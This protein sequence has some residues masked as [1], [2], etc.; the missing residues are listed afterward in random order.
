VSP[1]AEVQQTTC[2]VPACRYHPIYPDILPCAAALLQAKKISL[3]DTPVLHFAA[4]LV[5]RC[6]AALQR[7]TADANACAA[8]CVEGRDII[9]TLTSVVDCLDGFTAASSSPFDR[10]DAS[11]RVKP[12]SPDDD[13]VLASLIATSG[14]AAVTSRSGQT[15]RSGVQ[16]HSPARKSGVAPPPAIRRRMSS[17]VSLRELF[18]GATV[19][20]GLALSQ[21]S[22]CSSDTNFLGGEGLIQVGC[23][24]G[25]METPSP[26]TPCDV[27]RSFPLP[28]AARRAI[29]VDCRGSRQHLGV[30]S[31]CP[32]PD[33]VRH[34]TK[35]RGGGGARQ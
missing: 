34:G 31:C 22:A 35:G 2:S 32:A 19:S 7:L 10:F 8:L 30:S 6:A 20:V 24:M 28:R 11:Q 33:A 3:E 5:H 26:R 14:V 12:V 27:L 17:H 16:S 21:L 13:P 1:S 18:T 4:R 9:S 23:G 15:A 29:H 25:S